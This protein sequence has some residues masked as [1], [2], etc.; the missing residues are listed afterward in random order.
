MLNK[1]EGRVELFEKLKGGFQDKR[2]TG[3]ESPLSDSHLKH[4]R[5]G[6]ITQKDLRK[7]REKEKYHKLCDPESRPV[8]MLRKKQGKPVTGMQAQ[9]ESETFTNFFPFRTNFLKKNMVP[10]D[11]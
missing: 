7:I 10:G 1:P 5:E 11:R 6:D 2:R 3:G 4:L 9:K 8:H